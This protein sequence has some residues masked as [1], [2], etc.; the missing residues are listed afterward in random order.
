MRNQIYGEVTRFR[1][2]EGMLEQAKQAANE[3]A[4]TLSEFIRQS[5]IAQLGSNK[6]AGA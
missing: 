2:P 5:V 4:Q 1:R 6:Q 3:R